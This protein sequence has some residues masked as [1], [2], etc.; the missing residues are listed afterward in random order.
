MLCAAHA[1]GEEGE[2]SG[3][4]RRRN[5]QGHRHRPS[6]QRPSFHATRQDE[7]VLAG[8]WGGGV[9]VAGVAADLPLPSLRRARG[10]ER[11]RPCRLGILGELSVLH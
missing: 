1:A 7:Q 10:R 5:P 9:I 2:G 11:H 4:G 3:N 6:L 8:E